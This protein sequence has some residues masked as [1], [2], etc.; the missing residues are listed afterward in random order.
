MVKAHT[1]DR[2]ASQRLACKTRGEFLQHGDK[3]VATVSQTLV[4][5]SQSHTQLG[6]WN[7]VGTL[8]ADLEK[9]WHRQPAVSMF[10]LDPADYRHEEIHRHIHHGG[11]ARVP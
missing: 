9:D 11:D 7:N 2:H 1:G 3:T 4:E 5:E 10:G 6:L 8:I